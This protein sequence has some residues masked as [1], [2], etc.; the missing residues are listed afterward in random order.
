MVLNARRR[1]DLRGG[2][3]GELERIR[4]RIVEWM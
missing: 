1:G 3:R 2:E 4:V